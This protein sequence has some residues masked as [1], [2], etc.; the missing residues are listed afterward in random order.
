[1]EENIVDEYRSKLA[2][3]TFPES[4]MVVN[5]H[6]GSHIEEEDR[7]YIY[8]GKIIYYDSLKK[9]NDAIN[10]LINLFELQASSTCD[11]EKI[12][13]YYINTLNKIQK[14]IYNFIIYF[15]SKYSLKFNE[16]EVTSS[17]LFK[18]Y[19]NVLNERKRKI[20][21]KLRRIIACESYFMH[22]NCE[23]EL[24]KMRDTYSGF[25]L[26][27][28]DDNCDYYNDFRNKVK[29]M[30][31]SEKEEI[32]KLEGEKENGYK[33]RRIKRNSL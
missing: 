7:F 15:A 1:M 28:E 5:E 29:Y 4:H 18:T 6:T 32:E 19:I 30:I 27:Q 9:L 13:S 3:F 24:L 17:T 20:D 26:S 14:Q 25:I 12:Y 11:K 2:K 21:E 31:T 22:Y 23:N 16:E 8:E 10:E 33:C